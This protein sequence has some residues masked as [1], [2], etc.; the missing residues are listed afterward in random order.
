MPDS[1]IK[2]N[3]SNTYREVNMS[4]SSRIRPP[5]HR[6][7]QTNEIHQFHVAPPDLKP[8]FSLTSFALSLDVFHSLSSLCVR[9]RWF[10][11]L[12][13]RRLCHVCS[14]LNCVC[15][16][17]YACLRSIW[18]DRQWLR[19]PFKRKWAIKNVLIIFI[20][21]FGHINIYMSGLYAILKGP[22]GLTKALET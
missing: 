4:I 15:V 18:V 13:R 22:G 1:L 14:I 16:C 3:R 17:V 21:W 5:I 9:R 11:V 7:T 2:L 19:E 20:D 10:S 12:I 6:H 8:H